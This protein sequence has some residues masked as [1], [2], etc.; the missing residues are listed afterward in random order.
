VQSLVGATRIRPAV[1]TAVSRSHEKRGSSEPDLLELG[2]DSSHLLLVVYAQGLALG[3]HDAAGSALLRFGPPPADADYRGRTR[4]IVEVVGESVHPGL[5]RPVL[6][7]ETS[8]DAQQ[9]LSVQGGFDVRVG[10]ILGPDV[11]ADSLVLEIG[12]SEEHFEVTFVV[13]SVTLEL[14]WSL[15]DL[16]S[17]VL[18]IDLVQ[19]LESLRDNLDLRS[20]ATLLLDRRTAVH[21]E[22]SDSFDHVNAFVD[23]IRNRKEAEVSYDGVA[24]VVH[25]DPEFAHE[26]PFC[27]LHTDSVDIDRIRIFH[28][29]GAPGVVDKIFRHVEVCLSWFDHGVNVFHTHEVPPVFAVGIVDIP[30]GTFELVQVGLLYGYFEAYSLERG[31]SGYFVPSHWDLFPVLDH[32]TGHILI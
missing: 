14:G 32:V 29:S 16:S 3:L 9:I 11:L 2:V 12:L 1:G 13:G 28:Y 22:V 17:Y 27:L 4:L 25:L 10:A 6:V 21:G 23:Q 18:L 20:I 15:D 8:S 24:V 31:C 7:D 19:C 26:H 30:E 5:R